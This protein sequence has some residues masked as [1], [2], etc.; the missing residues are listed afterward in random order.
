MHITKE[1]FQKLSKKKQLEAKNEMQ[2]C[3][4][5]FNKNF[6]SITLCYFKLFVKAFILFL[7]LL[8]LYKIAFGSEILIIFYNILK[9]MF[10]IFKYA[11]FIGIALDLAQVI[12]YSMK[13]DKI[14]KKY[15]IQ[16]IE[17]RNGK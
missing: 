13:K 5:N 2:I 10:I 1:L 15:F 3:N 11:L 8:P 7:I 16:K 4:D 12:G 17:V 9:T 14:R 6:H